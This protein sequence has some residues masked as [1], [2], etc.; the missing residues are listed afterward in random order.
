[1][2]FISIK[3]CVHVPF[4]LVCVIEANLGNTGKKNVKFVGTVVHSQSS[5]P[6]PAS[7]QRSCILFSCL[8]IP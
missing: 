1:M 3:V 8:L 2:N 6:S 5:G 7:S 4:S